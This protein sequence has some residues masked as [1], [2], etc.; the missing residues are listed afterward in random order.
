V[1]EVIAVRMPNRVEP[2]VD[3]SAVGI[4]NVPWQNFAVSVDNIEARVKLDLLSRL[5]NA[6]EDIVEARIFGAPALVASQGGSLLDLRAPGW[7]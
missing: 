2:G 1:I 7:H 4:R 5:P 6:I 3:G